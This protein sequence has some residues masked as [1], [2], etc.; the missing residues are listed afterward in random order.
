MN[1]RTR[2]GRSDEISGFVLQLLM[3]PAATSAAGLPCRAIATTPG[4]QHLSMQ[5]ATAAAAASSSTAARPAAPAPAPA[6]QTMNDRDS[7]AGDA[8]QS[9]QTS[10]GGVVIQVRAVGAS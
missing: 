1:E 2:H 6:A 5:P 9:Q 7:G 8:K 4:E 3:G 10:S